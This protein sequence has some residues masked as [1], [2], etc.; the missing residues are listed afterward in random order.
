MHGDSSVERALAILEDLSTENSL[1][2]ADLCRRLSIPKSSATNILR[3]L[4]NR[5]YVLRAENGRYHLSTKIV[6]LTQASLKGGQLKK[7]AL[8]RLTQLVAGTRLAACIAILEGGEALYVEN[9][10]APSMK[11]ADWVARRMDAHACAAGKAILAH[12]PQAE[13]KIALSHTG[14]RRWTAKTI[15]NPGRLDHELEKVRR[16]GFSIDDEEY[17]TGLRCVAAPIFGP[18]GKIAGC[19]A[20]AGPCSLFPENQLSRGGEIA[21]A[22]GQTLSYQLRSYPAAGSELLPPKPAC[23]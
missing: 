9:V 17:M 19:I 5:G 12:L 8:P 20:L 23:E 21:R 14:M 6:H 2:H 4:L 11:L 13:V 7:A 10:D 15:T 1:S 16:Q 18:L 3:T 22:A